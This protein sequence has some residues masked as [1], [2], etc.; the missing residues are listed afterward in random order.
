MKGRVFPLALSVAL[1]AALA[2]GSA[3]AAGDAKK[4]KKIFNKCKACHS[5]K[6]G[7]NKIGP[8]LYGIIGR[9]SAS[10]EGYKY[11]KAMKA[12]GITWNEKTLSE[13]LTKPRAYVKGTKMGFPGL[14][15]QKQRDDVI[16]Y[17]KEAAQ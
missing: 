6:E 1:I 3:L 9:A 15:K 4:G 14:K 17:L 8:S 10:I 2:S 16:A 5:I 11:S 12:S 7:K 13:F